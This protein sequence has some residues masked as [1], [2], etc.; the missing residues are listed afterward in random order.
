VAL[1][2]IQIRVLVRREKRDTDSSSGHIEDCTGKKG[3]S[4]ELCSLRGRTE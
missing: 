3:D 1:D 4:K 2:L